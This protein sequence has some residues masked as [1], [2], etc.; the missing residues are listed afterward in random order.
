MR[1]ISVKLQG[2][3]IDSS[4]L[5][6]QGGAMRRWGNSVQRQ[7]VRNSK[8]AA[9]VNKRSNK[10][11]G[12]PPRGTLRRLITGRVSVIKATKSVDII[13]ESGADYSLAV[14]EGTNQIQARGISGPGTN[15]GSFKKGAKMSLPPQ[16]GP[17][18][19]FGGGPPTPFSA[20]R[21]YKGRVRGQAAQ[22]FLK[23][24]IQKTAVRH[25]ALPRKMK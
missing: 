19:G 20:P 15:R 7:M 12:N 25:P 24:G 1:R 21:I 2:Q 10:N 22:P 23:Q 17:R 6:E 8:A 18:G 11:R 9:P 4:P 16:P 3:Y 13:V 5:W 14:H